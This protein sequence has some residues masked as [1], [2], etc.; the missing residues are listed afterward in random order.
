MRRTCC[1]VANDD[2]D[3]DAAAAGS[4]VDAITGCALDARRLRSEWKLLYNI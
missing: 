3:D 4:Q 2:D 1:E